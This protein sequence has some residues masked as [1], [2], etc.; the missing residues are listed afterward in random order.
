[1]DRSRHQAGRCANRSGCGEPH[2]RTSAGGGSARLGA[3]AKGINP[4]AERE[5]QKKEAERERAESALTLDV[6]I[7]EWTLLYL[8]HRRERY[9]TEAVRAIRR[10]FPE[11]LKQPAAKITKNDAV[12]ALDKLVK[13][14][15]PVMAGRTLAY[16]LRRRVPVG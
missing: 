1:M 15:K 14:G 5:R 12:N 10:A 3:A 6:L 16:A 11:L 2:N 7:E 4:R 13:A 8:A 9:R